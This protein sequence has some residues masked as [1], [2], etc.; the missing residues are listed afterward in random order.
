MLVVTLAKIYIVSPNILD[1][2]DL[3]QT[4]RLKE[5]TN[6]PIG[7]LM[8]VSSVKVLQSNNALHFIIKFPV[9]KLPVRK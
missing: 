9:I 6:I 5:P 4:E 3:S 2:A 7:D 8:S 1:H